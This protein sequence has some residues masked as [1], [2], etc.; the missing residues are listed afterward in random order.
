MAQLIAIEGSLAGKTFAL[1]EGT[2]LGRSFDADIR[3]DELT[4]SRHHAKITKTDDGYILEDSGSGNGT[5]LN[6]ELITK[7]RKLKNGDVIT[8][9]HSVF[10]YEDKEEAIP[11]A[12]QVTLV[13][14]SGSSESTIVDTLDVKATIMD[15]EAP[16][17]SADPAELLKA[18]ERLRTV[19]EMSNAVQTKLN[20]DQ[21]LNDVM[22]SLFHVFP[23]VERCF[24]MLKSETG[25]KL[26]PKV[27]RQR[28]SRQ[29]EAVTVSRRIISEAVTRRIAILSADAM[30]DTR[31]AEAAS[32]VNFQIRSMMCAPLIAKD[33]L[34][35]IIH[36]D[37]SRQDRRFTM[38]DLELLTGVG[39]QTAL[40]IANAKLHERL[41]LRERMDRD[42]QL[43]RQ[44]QESFLPSELPEIP[45]MQFCASYRA[46]LEVGGDFYDFIPLSGERLGIV[47][48]DVAGKGMPAALM[49]ARLSSDVRF[50]AMNESQPKDVLAKL[51][52][53]VCATSPEAFVTLV[54]GVL[55]PATRKMTMANAGHPPPLL[56]KGGSKEVLPFEDCIGFPLGAAASVEYPQESF[57]LDPGDVLFIF[58]DGV[59]EAMNAEKDIYGMA[60][61]VNAM[62]AQ[63]P[64]V[65]QVMAGILEDIQEYVGNTRQSDDLTAVC[66]GVI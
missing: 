60:R 65:K 35:G 49:M 38:D 29:P 47:L 4:V 30:G 42:L 1:Q 40:A 19:V 24:I 21:I 20:L 13:D 41:L 58:S 57:V 64:T 22:E 34:L 8:L 56:R 23:Q 45:G 16:R 48:G 12:S 11:E 14:E 27:S 52:E 5:V 32:V 7:P 43:A 51:N 66:F 37:T 50:L 28:D 25:Q 15:L 39:N 2:V 17:R 31:F 36:L 53:Q 62:A 54:L 33:E 18:H 55:E 63:T 9:P 59:T 44:V 10:R 46:A 61:L 6:G 26:V 3:I